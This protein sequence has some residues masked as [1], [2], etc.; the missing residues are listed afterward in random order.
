MYHKK[1]A[2]LV[3]YDEIEVTYTPSIAITPTTPIEG[4]FICSVT[5]GYAGRTLRVFDAD[6]VEYFSYYTD[7]IVVS[8]T[9]T[10]SI[11]AVGPT[12]PFLAYAL[13]EV[14]E[15][16]IQDTS[17]SYGTINSIDDTTVTILTSSRSGTFFDSY[18]IVGQTSGA[19]PAQTGDMVEKQQILEVNDKIKLELALAGAIQYLHMEDNPEAEIKEKTLMSLIKKN[20]I[21]H[22][23]K[24]DYTIRIG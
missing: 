16:V 7:S 4:G 13:L 22:K 1:P 17:N 2:L 10:I 24:T 6:D 20:N 14:G 11:E 9:N 8:P 19:N 23:A 12:Y 21:M 3:A 15:V 5:D 18:N